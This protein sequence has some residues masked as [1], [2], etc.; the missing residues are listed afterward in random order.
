MLTL[1]DLEAC[2]GLT[3]TLRTIDAYARLDSPV[4]I[5]GETTTARL[6]MPRLA[7]GGSVHEIYCPLA[8]AVQ[9]G[10]YEQLQAVARATGR[11]APAVVAF[12][13]VNRISVVDQQRVLAVV[14]DRVIDVRATQI[15]ARPVAHADTRGGA[16][17]W[18][19]GVCA[20]I[21]VPALGQRTED[22][23]VLL[24]RLLERMLN[25]AVRIDSLAEEALTEHTWPGDVS[26]LMACVERIV[27]AWP[28]DRSA[29]T[30]YAQDLGIPFR[31]A[32]ARRAKTQATPGRTLEA[33]LT[34]YEAEVV[35]LVMTRLG[36]NK[37]Q[38]ARE[39]GISRS[40]LIQKCQKYGI[41]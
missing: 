6:L 28:D 5:R 24:T 30:V 20:E 10:M 8:T 35:R 16:L 31:S 34:E 38:A 29:P 27:G 22:A 40:Y 25:R 26:E 39:L 4:L 11:R 18:P 33:M 32:A 17:V 36:G 7:N 1:G 41:E 13:E 3:P 19:P 21:A 9:T 15:T 23:A 14:R 37:S 2:P 12:V